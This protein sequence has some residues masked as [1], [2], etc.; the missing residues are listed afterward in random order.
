MSLFVISIPKKNPGVC[1]IGRSHG[2]NRCF[3]CYNVFYAF[4]RHMCIQIQNMIKR[5]FIAFGINDTESPVIGRKCRPLNL[6]NIG[7]RIEKL[8]RVKRLGKDSRRLKPKIRTLRHINKPFRH[9][10]GINIKF[11]K[12]YRRRFVSLSQSSPQIIKKLR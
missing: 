11:R 6:C 4:N 2:R 8:Y 3:L 7:I 9:F 5:S 10:R 12:N 1:F